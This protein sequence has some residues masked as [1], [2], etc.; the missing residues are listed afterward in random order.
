MAPRLLNA[1]QAAEY[2]GRSEHA[3]RQM[4]HRRQ[5]PFNKVPGSSVLRFDVRQLDRWIDQ[6]TVPAEP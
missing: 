2:I 1:A 4:V 3:I 5:I 6:H